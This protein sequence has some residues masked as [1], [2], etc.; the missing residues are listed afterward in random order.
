MEMFFMFV[1]LFVIFGIRILLIN[2]KLKKLVTKKQVEIICGKFFL[3]KVT[4]ENF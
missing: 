2:S 3:T 1:P 4:M